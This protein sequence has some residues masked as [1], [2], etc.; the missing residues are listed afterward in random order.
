MCMLI[1]IPIYIHMWAIKVMVVIRLR[2]ILNYQGLD[3]TF[4]FSFKKKKNPSS[5]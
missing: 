1:Y 5:H 2:F 3:L 4:L